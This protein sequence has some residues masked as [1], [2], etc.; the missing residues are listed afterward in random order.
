[1]IYL[2][3]AEIVGRIE[4]LLS[5]GTRIILIKRSVW[6]FWGDLPECIMKSTI[7]KEVMIPFSGSGQQAR[8]RQLLRKL[9]ELKVT[10]R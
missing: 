3:A 7:N 4:P 1:V 5:E 9:L 8:Y 10:D 6:N 2:P